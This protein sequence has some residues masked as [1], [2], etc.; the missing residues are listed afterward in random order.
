MIMLR[1]ILLFMIISL[2]VFPFAVHAQG[3]VGECRAS[4]AEDF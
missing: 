4:P 3:D 1:R 2:L